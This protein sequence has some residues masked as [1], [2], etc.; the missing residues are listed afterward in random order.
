V[1]NLYLCTLDKSIIWYRKRSLGQQVLHLRSFEVSTLHNWME[2]RLAYIVSNQWTELLDW[3][4]AL[5]FEL[6]K[7]IDKRRTG[8]GLEWI[9]CFCRPLQKWK[10]MKEAWGLREMVLSAVFGNNNASFASLE[11]WQEDM[12]VATILQVMDLYHVKQ[13]CLLSPTLFNLLHQW[14]NWG[15]KE[16]WLRSELWEV[17][18]SSPHVSWRHCPHGR[19]R[20]GPPVHACS[21]H[22]T[23]GVNVGYSH[24]LGHQVVLLLSPGFPWASQV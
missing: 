8:L 9:F 16:A 11:Y 7:L 12:Q 21:M 6:Q 23:P 20:R 13:G 22:F 5:T 3:T 14:P 10:G 19:N 24:K 2:R 17:D 4:T 15:D 18:P 1:E